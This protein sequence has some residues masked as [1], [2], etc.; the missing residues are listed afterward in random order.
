MN[1][2]LGGSLSMSLR[3]QCLNTITDRLYDATLGMLIVKCVGEG[4]ESI[5]NWRYRG[6][7]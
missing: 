7:I 2:I 4:T 1:M 6:K 5:I 3:D